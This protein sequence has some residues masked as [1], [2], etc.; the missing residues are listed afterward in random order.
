M[1]PLAPRPRERLV[2]AS[3]AVVAAQAL[4]PSE[5]GASSPA[6]AAATVTLPKVGR[7]LSADFRGTG[8]QLTTRSKLPGRDVGSLA[9]PVCALE[10][11]VASLQGS[12]SSA[13]SSASQARSAPEQATAGSHSL[14]GDEA[15]AHHALLNGYG[16]SA[17]GGTDIPSDAGWDDLWTSTPPS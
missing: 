17:P 13:A 10:G 5:A 4:A 8:A 9:G 15:F 3:A 2:S 1:P 16:T 11:S 14:T 6:V 12:A 7:T